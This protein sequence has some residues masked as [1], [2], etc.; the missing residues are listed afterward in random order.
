MDSFC[1]CF[2]LINAV[3]RCTLTFSCRL[4]KTS[5]CFVLYLRRTHLYKSIR[6][7]CAESWLSGDGFSFYTICVDC[8]IDKMNVWTIARSKGEHTHTHMYMAIMMYVCPSSD[9]NYL[10]H[11]SDAEPFLL[12]GKIMMGNEKQHHYHLNYYIPPGRGGF[13][14]VSPLVVDLLFSHSYQS[15]GRR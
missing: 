13:T 14:F 1:F 10:E 2:S 6:K 8:L 15:K 4:T 11:W 9:V 3:F 7:D 5:S 12:R